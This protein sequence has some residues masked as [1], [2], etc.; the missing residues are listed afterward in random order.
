MPN[1]GAVL[2]EEITRLSRKELRRQLAGM[3]KA[4]VQYR[5]HIAALRRQIGSVERQVSV[6][7]TRMMERTSQAATPTVAT[8]TRFVAK[9]LRSHRARLGLS[10]EAYGRLAGVSAQTI[11]SWE[12][13]TSTPRAEQRASLAAIRGLGK[14]EARARLEA[15]T[16]RG[17]KKRRRARK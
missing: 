14:R 1:V 3:R 8:Q 7:R 13:E 9:G 4:S 2:K 5:R 6:L 16:S 11:Y 12:G 10:A 15:A 17:E